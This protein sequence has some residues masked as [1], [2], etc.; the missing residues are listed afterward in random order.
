LSDSHPSGLRI[1]FFGTPAFAA[2]ILEYLKQAGENIVG[3]VTTPEKQQGRG[4]KTRPMAMQEAAQKFEIPVLAP[5]KLRDENF[6][7]EM[8]NLHADIFCVVAYKILPRE[9]FTMPKFGAFN[10]HTSL[11]PKYRGAAPM[12]W[13]IINGEKETGITTFLLDD[14]VDTGNILMQ[15]HVPITEDETVGDLHDTLM[16]L[17]A[18]LALDTI[19]GLANNS[20]T[21]RPQS[22]EGSSPAPKIF[23]ADCILDFSLSALQVHNKI[24]GLSP[25]PT[26]VT[27][28]PNGEGLKVF[29]STVSSDSPK[30]AEG[31]F[32]VSQDKKHLFVGTA[33]R[34][35][36]LLE[37]QRE[38][39]KRMA[40][41]EF[42]RGALHIF[43]T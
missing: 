1:V 19:R 28:L 20:L 25:Y 41:E 35:I 21:P 42:L 36:E 14:K 37:V 2:F 38:N 24:R 11:L 3:V 27:Q 39:K 26:A 23:P 29:R 15:S 13:A 4:L 18:R 30:L 7:N 8:K 17:G 31:V 22:Q 10:V 5:E 32:S 43:T 40:A 33:T 6:L 34:A 12:N 16:H 9:V